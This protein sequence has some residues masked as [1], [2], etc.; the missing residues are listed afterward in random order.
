MKDVILKKI[1]TATKIYE[2]YQ[3][4]LFQQYLL[5]YLKEACNVPYIDPKRYEKRED[6]Y[7]AL[8]VA[9]IEAG[10]YKQLIAFL[11]NQKEVAIKL[12]Q[13]LES[14]PKSS[15]IGYAP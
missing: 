1:E 8:D 9:N 5:P 3:S 6:Y 7:F 2:L 4:E 13:K 12:R 10:V 11:E 14:T 15:N